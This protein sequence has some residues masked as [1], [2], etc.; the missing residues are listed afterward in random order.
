MIFIVK[1][2]DILQVIDI[3]A[4]PL[5]LIISF[6]LH[7]SLVPILSELYF[8][9]VS[10]L[11]E[12]HFVVFLSICSFRSRRILLSAGSDWRLIL[13]I[14]NTISMFQWPLEN[15]QEGS[16]VCQGSGMTFH[17]FCQLFTK[18][19]VCLKRVLYRTFFWALKW[20][21][22]TSRCSIAFRFCALIN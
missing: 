8:S 9:L 11:S 2:N 5:H 14:Y 18:F 1:I 4:G 7:F 22:V 13:T 15:I 3:W 21:E 19:K 6:Q 10:I 20:N 12:L 17:Q 16:C